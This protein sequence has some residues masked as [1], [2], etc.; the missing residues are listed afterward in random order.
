M[1]EHKDQQRPRLGKI[2]TDCAQGHVARDACA[3]ADDALDPDIPLHILEDRRQQR[4]GAR[5]PLFVAGQRLDLALHEGAH[6]EHEP[7]VGSDQQ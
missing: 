2:D 1:V 6:D 4:C 7:D 5:N 3:R